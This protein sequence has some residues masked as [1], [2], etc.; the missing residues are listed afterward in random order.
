MGAGIWE[1]LV[2]RVLLQPLVRLPSPSFPTPVSRPRQVM[3]AILVTIKLA[4]PVD[5]VLGFAIDMEGT[6]IVE[7][8]LNW[9]RDSIGALTFG[10]LTDL[11]ETAD[12]SQLCASLGLALCSQRVSTR[13]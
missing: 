3:A 8:P 7:W 2:F 1:E 6:S 4:T 9:M 5:F 12:F 11:Y 13:P 10:L